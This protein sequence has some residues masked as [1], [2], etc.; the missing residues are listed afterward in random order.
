MTHTLPTPR[1]RV[2]RLLPAA[3]LTPCR[4]PL[5]HTQRRQTRGPLPLR[6]LTSFQSA[7]TTYKSWKL[8][9]R[10]IAKDGAARFCSLISARSIARFTTTYKK[11]GRCDLR[12]PPRPVATTATCRGDANTTNPGAAL[13]EGPPV[14]SPVLRSE[15][16]HSLQSRGRDG[17]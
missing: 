6:R 9:T 10:V 7:S 16:C 11:R 13:R 17:P 1:G 15:L 2:P 12:A 5:A 4:R 3:L 8:L 14:A